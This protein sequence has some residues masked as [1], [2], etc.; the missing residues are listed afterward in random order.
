[1]A[2]FIE[3]NVPED[4]VILTDDAQSLGIMLLS[5]RPDLF[6]DRIDRGDEV[7][8]RALNDPF[9]E[10][11]Y[12]LVTTDERCRAPCVDFVRERYPGVL[13]D[14]VPGMRVVFRTKQY[15]L[16]ELDEEAPRGPS[17]GDS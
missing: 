5:G 16:I 15:V 7:W 8:R 17:K 14:K 6:F 9:G 3:E 10:I 1:M 11:N 12:F 2:D 4:E 13:R